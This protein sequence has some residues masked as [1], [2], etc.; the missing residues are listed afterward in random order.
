MSDL[1]SQLRAGDTFSQLVAQPDYPASAGWELKLRLTPRDA[2]AAAVELS[3]SAE[4]SDHRLQA[5]AAATAA[6]PTGDCAA[7]MWVEK[8]GAV[9]TVASAQLRILPNLRSAPAGTD[10][11]SPARQALAAAEAALVAYGAHAYLQGIVIGERQKRFHTPGEFMA[12]VSQLRQQV[13]RED[14]AERL[15]QG[16]SPRNRLLVRFT[17]R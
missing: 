16:L 2:L 8:A 11:R 4:G 10:T 6:W 1:P 7:A 5:S 12:F 17:G 14:R 3:A 15:E 13:A 9:H